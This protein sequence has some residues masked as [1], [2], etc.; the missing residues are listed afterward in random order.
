MNSE[1]VEITVPQE[2]VNDEVVRLVNWLVEPGEEVAKDQDVVE[3]ES[4]KAVYALVAPARGYIY[5]NIQL[6][7]D[8][9]VGASICYLSQVPLDTSAL[10]QL[11]KRSEALAPVDPGLIVSG[12]GTS[13][14]SKEAAKIIKEK[15]IDP[16]VLSGHGLVRK[17]DVLSYLSHGEVV[18]LAGSRQKHINPADVWVIHDT[19]PPQGGFG[20]YSRQFLRRI[21]GGA[22]A[23][24]QVSAFRSVLSDF[25]WG[26][27]L[28]AF[29]VIWV[30]AKIP[31]I[32]SWLEIIA[33]IYKRNMFGFFLRGTY[34]K[35]KLKKMGTDV[36]ID[37]GVEIWGPKNVT[38]GSGCH[39]DMNARIAAGESGQG[40]HGSVEIGS[41]VH[42]GPMTQ[43]AGRGG[44]KI[45]SYTAIT[46]GTKI[47]SATNTGDNP[48]APTDLL[49]MS[50]AAPLER[51]RII[52]APVIVED[53]VFV[54]LNVCILPGVKIGRGAI[55][56]SG[57]VVTR[58]IPA[59]A[60]IKGAT[61]S[62]AGVRLPRRHAGKE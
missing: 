27:H 48:D 28:V 2:N 53:H 44:I 45:G 18:K 5:Y 4:S 29:S 15:G 35:A 41:H 60:I 61:M 6:G 24:G 54:G 8:V 57:A 50:H 56:N 36:I 59:F 9:K 58:D 40:Q 1:I 37:Q 13:R 47:F 14:F 38:I 31:V 55:I 7:C 12:T 34:Y 43:L 49:P 39:L 19:E 16:S 17:K 62:V 33:R 3:L 23:G 42:I 32:S 11:Y 52:E 22:Y 46:A 25:A 26:C 51:Q 21:V 30:L 10:E 20:I